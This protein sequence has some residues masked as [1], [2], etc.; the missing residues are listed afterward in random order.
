MLRLT[1]VIVGLAMI[2]VGIVCW[3]TPASA[4]DATV[5]IENFQ[6]DPQSVTVNVGDSVTWTNAD[7]APHQISA[8]DDSFSTG[9]INPGASKT[10][11][12]NTPGTFAYHCDI[13]PAETATLTVQADED[14]TTSSTTTTTNPTTTSTAPPETTPTS[15]A[16][17][18]TTARARALPA[19][20]R[21]TGPMAGLGL[22]LVVVGALMVFGSQ[23]LRP[24]RGAH[25][26]PRGAHFPR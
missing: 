21:E 8:N 22:L 14:T 16:V 2:A 12:F 3:T 10:L 13:H 19:T 11:V 5:T 6:I 4:A 26:K 25:F 17:T 7:S 1:R 15:Q 23:L 18:T 20:G 24:V 9:V